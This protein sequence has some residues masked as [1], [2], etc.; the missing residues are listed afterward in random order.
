[1]LKIEYFQMALDTGEMRS[2]GIKIAFFSKKLQ[3]IV[4]RLGGFAS[5]PP[6]VIRLNYS[7][8]LYSNSSPQFR[9][10]LILTIGLSPLFERVPSYVPTPGH[11][12]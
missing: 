10:F 2:N 1:M 5:R 8:H 9:H 4:Q 12:F 6:S 7:T 3:K 11:R